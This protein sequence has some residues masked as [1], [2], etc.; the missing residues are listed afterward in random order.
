MFIQLTTRYQGNP[1]IWYNMDKVLSLHIKNDN[2]LI[3]TLIQN[4]DGGSHG[5]LETP[6]QIMKLIK[7][8]K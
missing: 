5:V 8:A 3:Y 7:Q 6:E 1:L 2:G 4:N